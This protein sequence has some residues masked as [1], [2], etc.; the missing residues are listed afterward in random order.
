MTDQLIL[1]GQRAEA[2]AGE[3][4]AVESPASAQVVAHVAK[5]GLED[6]TRAVDIATRAFDSGV[7]SRFNPTDRGRIL[8]KVAELILERLDEFAAFEQIDAGHPIA[9]A[10]GEVQAAAATF[11]FY[12]G[13]IDK[14]QSSVYPINDSGISLS[15]RDPIGPCALIVP[16]NFP[17]MIAAWKVAP[18]LAA[19]NPI[20]LKPASLTPRS[21]LLLGDVLVEAGVPHEAVSVLPGPGGLIGDALV[22]HPRVA[23]VSFTGETTTGA[24]ILRASADNITR[25]TL[26]LGGKSAAVV[27]GDVDVNEV[28]A[29]M[30]MGV[31]DNTGQDCC[32]RS[33]ILVERSIYDDF[34]TEFAKQTDALI[35][36]DPAAE[37]TQVGPLIS[38]AQRETSRDYIAIGK[39]EGAESVTGG[40]TPELDGYYLTPCVLTDVNNSMRVAR[41]EIFGPVACVIPF[42]D[43]AEAVAIAN[44]SDYG[45]SGSLWTSDA[46]R[47]IRVAKALRTGTLSVNSNSSVRV[48]APFGGY[49]K[50]GLGRELGMNALDNYTETKTVYFAAD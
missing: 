45:L 20:I 37:N 40:T 4:F 15:L 16:W 11:A 47:A 48:Q 49:K 13:A 8:A 32:S 2:L 38:S 3:T 9:S 22:A 44:D 34:V 12:A 6:V 30:P 26:E 1:A 18:A 27:F 33:R 7:W 24:S 31:F 10:R 5:A 14:Y 43:E 21:A 29:K 25:V 35:V 39:N 23:K 42:D 19:G 17:L 50:S 28:A 46:K 41:E 36:G